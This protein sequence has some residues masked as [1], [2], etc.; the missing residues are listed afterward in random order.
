M[1]YVWS[2]RELSRATPRSSVGGVQRPDGAEALDAFDGA[3][4]EAREPQAA[5]AREAL[6]RREVVD[7][8]LFGREAHAARGR[9]PVDDDERVTRTRVGA[10][11]TVT[12]VDVSLCG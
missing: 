11:G 6:L 1:L 4:R 9:R 8:E 3:G 12:P 2:W 10:A 5:V 7:V